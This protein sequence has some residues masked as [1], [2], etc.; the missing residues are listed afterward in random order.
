MVKEKEILMPCIA[1]YLSPGMVVKYGSCGHETLN[2]EY[3]YA[4][5]YTFTWVK[6]K[7]W[8]EEV[9]HKAHEK[10]EIIVDEEYVDSQRDRFGGAPLWCL[11]VAGNIRFDWVPKIKKL[12]DE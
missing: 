6:F 8:E 5:G 9:F 11:D 4:A 12:K 7:E 2:V 1:K 10:F 3:S